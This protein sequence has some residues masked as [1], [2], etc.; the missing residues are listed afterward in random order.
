VSPDFI[1]VEPLGAKGKKR[2][3]KKE[4]GMREQRHLNFILICV[5][6]VLLCS[7]GANAGTLTTLDIPGATETLVYDID[8]DNII[9]SYKTENDSMYHGFIYDGTTWNTIDMPGADQTMLYAIDGSV[10]VGS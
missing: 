6:A 2:R 9:G 10:I 7:I 4:K 3:G 8:G 1:G 5:A